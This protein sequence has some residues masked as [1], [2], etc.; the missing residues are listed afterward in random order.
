MPRKVAHVQY[1]KDFVRPEIHFLAEHNLISL[2]TVG[3]LVIVGRYGTN[4]RTLKEVIQVAKPK[5]PMG[6]KG[7]K[8]P[9]R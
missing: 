9:A 3:E 2:V 1:H 7:Q 8:K 6:G 4:K 5:K